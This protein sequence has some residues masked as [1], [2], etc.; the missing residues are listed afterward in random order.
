MCPPTLTN[1]P[2]CFHNGFISKTLWP[3]FQSG[4][5]LLFCC[6]YTCCG[7]VFLCQASTSLSLHPDGL[8]CCSE[9]LLRYV[10]LSWWAGWGNRV[11]QILLNTK[12]CQDL[13]P[14]C[15]VAPPT[16]KKKLQIINV[17]PKCL[18]LQFLSVMFSHF[19]TLLFTG[20]QL[21]EHDTHLHS[22]RDILIS[23]V[24]LLNM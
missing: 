10:S 8:A 16:K 19:L 14:V 2:V 24:Q 6:C 12:K 20:M 13:F 1:V 3:R 22:I 9:P 4:V 18:S 15:S 17:R 21:S 5:H 7:I 23:M 11:E